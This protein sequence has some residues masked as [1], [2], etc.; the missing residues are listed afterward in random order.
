MEICN[1]LYKSFTQLC[2]LSTKVCVRCLQLV[3]ENALLKNQLAALQDTLKVMSETQRKSSFSLQVITAPYKKLLLF[4][5]Y[6]SLVLW[7]N[8]FF[9]LFKHDYAAE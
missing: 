7:F 3:S 5:I 1:L 2:V 8:V 4:A 9:F 6:V